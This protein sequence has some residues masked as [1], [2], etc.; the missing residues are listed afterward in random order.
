MT[1]ESWSPCLVSSLIRSEPLRDLMS[2]SLPTKDL[3]HPA[4]GDL[5]LCEVLDDDGPYREIETAPD[6]QMRRLEPGDRFV[7]VLGVRESA[8]NVTGTVPHGPLVIGATLHLLAVAAL[9]GVAEYVPAVAS[10]HARSLAFLGGFHDSKAVPL[11]LREWPRLESVDPQAAG[12][13]RWTIVCGASAEV[14]KTTL[15]ERLLLQARKRDVE[16]GAVKLTGTGRVK[17]GQRY[18]RAGATWVRDFTDAGLETTYAVS[19]ALLARMLARLATAAE[20]EGIRKLVAEFGGDV[21]EAGVPFLAPLLIRHGARFAFVANDAMSASKALEMLGPYAD[22]SIVV[23]G[24]NLRALERRLKVS[25]VY[26]TDD[27]NDVSDLF[28]Y[29]VG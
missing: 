17:D 28:R 1:V 5:V 12:S 7:G 25:R 29:L 21:L 18:S 2:R 26:D 10:R 20:R 16:L 3:E 14:G 6:A 11:N 4:A 19:D 9:V 27:S 24:G 13:I 15:V 8:V 22:V 23:R